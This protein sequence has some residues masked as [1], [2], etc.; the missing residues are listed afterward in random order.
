M[1]DEQSFSVFYTNLEYLGVACFKP[2]R[3]MVAAMKTKITPNLQR[4][5]LGDLNHCELDDVEV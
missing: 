2:S 1:S 3:E 4:L 5:P